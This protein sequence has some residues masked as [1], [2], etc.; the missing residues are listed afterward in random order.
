MYGD[1]ILLDR[2]NLRPVATWRWTPEGTYITHYNHRVVERVFEPVHGRPRR[3]VETMDVEPYSALG[4]ELVAASLPLGDGYRG[5]LPVVVDTM[6]RGW[7]WLH[8]TVQTQMLVKERPDQV[9]KDMWIVDCDLDGERTR[10]WIA[11]EGHSLRKIQTL[12]QDNEV[13]T[14]IRRMLL[15]VPKTTQR[16]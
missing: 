11:Q 3:S 9:E 14:E 13:K 1:S 16:P 10:L 8:F 2:A 6:P 4:M 12:T 7:S 15:S 5:Q